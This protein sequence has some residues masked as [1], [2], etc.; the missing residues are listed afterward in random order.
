RTNRSRDDRSLQSKKD[1]RESRRVTAGVPVSGPKDAWRSWAIALAG[2]RGPQ[3]LA[4][5]ERLFAESY[6]P[7]ANAIAAGLDDPRALP[8]YDDFRRSFERS[9][10]D[11]F[12]A[13]GAT[14]RRPRLVMDAYDIA[15]KQARLSNARSSHVLVV[16]SMRFDL[17]CL[18]RDALTR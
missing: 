8:A 13:F 9:Y 1:R 3:P 2:A 18:V 6:V 15:S 11:A 14:N 5:F 10:T 16:D 7:L 12:N 17:G 4:A